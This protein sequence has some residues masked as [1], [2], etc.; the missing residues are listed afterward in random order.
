MA[1]ESLGTQTGDSPK[2]PTLR[3]Y[4]KQHGGKCPQS[5]NVK[6]IFKPG[7][8][9]GF[10]IVTDH[11]Y[12]VQ[13]L[14]DNPLHGYLLENIDSLQQEEATLVVR[15]SD[16][17]RVQWE[18]TRS[19]DDNSSWNEFSWVYKLALMPRKPTLGKTGATS[20]TKTPATPQG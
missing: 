10:S 6:I 8:Y 13:V 7:K 9:G 4:I 18:L 3:Q 17:E 16:T 14:E 19:T 20:R 12:R 1:Y 5:S 2:T 15:V 11:N